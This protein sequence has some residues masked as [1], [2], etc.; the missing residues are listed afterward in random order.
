LLGANIIL[1]DKTLGILQI[2][3]LLKKH[4]ATNIFMTPLMSRL[5]FSYNNSIVPLKNNLNFITIGGDKPNE[6][7]VKKLQEIFKCPIYSTYGLAEAGPRVS[8]KKIDVNTPLILG[9]GKPNPN[10]KMRLVEN[11][12]YQR[13][14][15]TKKI[16]YLNIQTDSIYLGY[17]TGDKLQKPE[18]NTTLKTRD[19]CLIDNDEIH[20]LGR[21]GDYTIKNEKMIWFYEIANN[22]YK[23]PNVLKVKIKKETQDKLKFIIYHRKKVTANDFSGFLLEKYNL[24]SNEEYSMELVEFN[25]NQYK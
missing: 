6:E 12:E 22:F 18:S 16:G 23:N 8:T 14:S 11:Q 15:K 5:L 17:I 24:T 20:L 25:N 3:F 7:G 9:L 10:I 19:V 2:P 1:T 13:L 21:D 4:S